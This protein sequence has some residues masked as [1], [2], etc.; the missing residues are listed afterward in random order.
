MLNP[1]QIGRLRKMLEAGQPIE[2][3]D[4]FHI[5]SEIVFV[6]PLGKEPDVLFET[7][8]LTARFY[9]PERLFGEPIDPSCLAGIGEWIA[10]YPTRRL[11]RVS[12]ARVLGNTAVSDASGGLYGPDF[13]DTPDCLARMLQANSTDYQGFVL[14]PHDGGAMAT[15]LAARN[16][17]RLPL[18]PLF[19][20]NLESGNYGSFLIRQLLQMQIPPDLFAAFDC[21]LVPERTPWFSEAVALLGLPDLPT[22]NVREIA[23]QSLDSVLI[24]SNADTEGFI[25]SEIRGGLIQALIGRDCLDGPQGHSVL[26]T[27]LQGRAADRS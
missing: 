20:H 2:M 5:R 23:G 14:R 19:F 22:F 4:G 7:P 3:F 12:Q 26:I 10:E 6:A 9:G 8:A 16:P 25:P 11:A 1:D 21:Y 15:F 17:R 24:W 27:G 18:N 13:I